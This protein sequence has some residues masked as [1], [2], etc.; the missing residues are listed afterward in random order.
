MK[1]RL[2]LPGILL[3][4]MPLMNVFGDAAQTVVVDPAG[5]VSTLK[6]AR[7]V[8]REMRAGGEKGNI[9][10]Q[11]H[12]GT[13]TLDETLIFGLED[14]APDGAVTRYIA[15]DGAN[16]LISG[17]KTITGWEKTDLQG[18]MIWKA[19]VPW[20]KGDAFFHCLYDG[21]KLLPRARSEGFVANEQWIYDKKRHESKKGFPKYAG[22]MKYRTSF[23][24]PGDIVQDWDNLEDVEVYGQPNRK[25]LVNYLGIQ[26]VDVENKVAQLTV[27]AT[28]TMTGEFFV[29]NRIEYLDTP[30]EWVLNSK[31]GM[32]YYWPESGTPG[33]QI[34]APAL[35]ELF[36]VEGVSD[37]SLA[38]SKE[39]QVEGI[40]FVGLRLAYA[41]R[42]RW[43]PDDI[44]IQ[45]DWNL[46]DKANG[47]IR[48]R[49]AVRCAVRDCTFS[50]SGSDGV[51]MDLF[52]QNITVEGSTFR[53][54]G[55]TGVLL[56]GYGPGQK[57]VNKNNV[58]TENEFVRVG[59]IFQHSPGIFIWQSGHN[60]IS[61]NHIHDLAYTGMVVAGVR[62]RFFNPKFEEMGI[63]NDP[64]K[65]W[66][67]PA[68]TREHLPTIRW[69]E[70]TLTD[71][72][73]WDA[74]AP[75]MHARGNVIEY[76]EVHDVL[77]LLHDGNCIY[78]SAHGD[79]NIVR[80][81]AT[82]NHPK[83]AMI[84]TDDDSHGA[85][86]SH[87]LMIGTMS[88]SGYAMK[89]LNEARHNI[90]IN[91]LL[92]TG[93]AGNTIHPKSILEKNLLYYTK[94]FES[95]V[96]NRFDCLEG[97][98][99]ENLYY[100]EQGGAEKY[101][102]KF[103]AIV[104]SPGA[105]TDSVAADPLFTD[106]SK[107]DLSFKSGSPAIQLGIDPMPREIIAKMG[108]SRDPFIERYQEVFGHLDQ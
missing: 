51:R 14:S 79:G 39:K 58:V 2:T 10:V 8:V 100:S 68:G 33:E 25:W 89:G 65:I 12:D 80:Y 48:F 88:R 108:K 29:E 74:Y 44:G 73:E 56:S 35:T 57:D 64:F 78:L 47:L 46:W 86:V 60:T 61:H 49:G 106:L 85:E 4:W 50:D 11:L 41:D 84:R 69:E 83:G 76:N 104:K 26:S 42:Q 52:C 38:G 90:L 13:Y 20:A 5:K 101:L 9:D 75:Y 77:K 22:E 66:D 28:Y 94:P 34:I 54:L 3:I 27:P 95:K 92:T 105:E 103:R 82:Y 16:P 31:E 72:N 93:G 21:T 43:L 55:G 70:I 45:H 24:F 99:N 23:T 17:G 91:S 59:Q 62:R 19:P 87:N 6:A 71:T 37:H 96:N 107:G 98:S 1:N 36:R 67:F 81:N 53:D 30:G 40:E 7:D 63:T 97:G 102:E 18:G 15:A 32:L